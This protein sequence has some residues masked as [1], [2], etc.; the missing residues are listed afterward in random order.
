MGYNRRLDLNWDSHTYIGPAAKIA[1]VLSILPFWVTSQAPG[2][3]RHV[4]GV[5]EEALL[6]AE[7][8]NKD[9][10][11]NTVCIYPNFHSNGTWHKSGLKVEDVLSTIYG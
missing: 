1:P 6:R 2:T 11:K 7:F 10:M 8:K 5:V 3:R 4:L 9:R